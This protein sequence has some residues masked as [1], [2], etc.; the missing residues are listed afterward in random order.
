MVAEQRPAVA[1]VSSKGGAFNRSPRTSE[2]P[3][4]KAAKAWGGQSAADGEVGVALLAVGSWGEAIAER[5]RMIGARSEVEDDCRGAGAG[6][7]GPPTAG[8]PASIT[9]DTRG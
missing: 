2:T 9:T 1:R 8:S 5:M 3:R 6:S 7:T 4:R